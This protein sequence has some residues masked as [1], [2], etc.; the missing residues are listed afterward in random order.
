[1]ELL[2]L[3]D[4]LE[5]A[6]DQGAH[7][8]GS[9]VLLDEARLRRLIAEMRRRVP[10]E[11]KLMQRLAQDRDRI[12]SETRGQ[13]RR[14]VEEAQAYVNVRLEEHNTVH[15]ARERAREIIGEAEQNAD[16]MRADANAYVANQLN[17]LESR[18]QRVLHEVQAGQR[19]LAP[20]PAEK[21][22]ETPDVV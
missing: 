18:L 13:A 8:P 15:A 5:K 21:K 3:I 9:R 11:A 6:V 17:A 7:L 19:Y 2:D 10:D 22:P 12:L 14:I 16:R 20:P 1:M 4:E